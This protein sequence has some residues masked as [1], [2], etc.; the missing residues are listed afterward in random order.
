MIEI[1][2]ANQILRKPG[3]EGL[4]VER[5]GGMEGK[6]EASPHPLTHLNIR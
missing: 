2:L 4:E 1:D 3:K 5:P 6:F